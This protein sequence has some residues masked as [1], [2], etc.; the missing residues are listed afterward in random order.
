MLKLSD[1]HVLHSFHW[2]TLTVTISGNSISV[3]YEQNSKKIT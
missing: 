3:L 2:A 1:S